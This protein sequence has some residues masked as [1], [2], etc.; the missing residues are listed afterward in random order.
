MDDPREGQRAA[1]HWSGEGGRSGKAWAAAFWTSKQV[2]SHLQHS[3][4]NT[5]SKRLSLTAVATC[6]Y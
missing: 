2:I 1:W 4:R 6:H 3:A 5:T